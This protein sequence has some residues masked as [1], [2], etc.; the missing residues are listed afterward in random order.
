VIKSYFECLIS[1]IFVAHPIHLP[2]VMM[3]LPAIFVTQTFGKSKDPD[4]QLVAAFG[5]LPQ[6]GRIIGCRNADVLGEF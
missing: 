6:P 4:P 3:Y 1:N 5:S 2:Q